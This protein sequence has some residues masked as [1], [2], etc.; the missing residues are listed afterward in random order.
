MNIRSAAAS[1][2]SHSTPVHIRHITLRIVAMAL[3]RGS[4]FQH[5]KTRRKNIYQHIEIEKYIYVWSQI[6]STPLRESTFSGFAHHL[7][8]STKRCLE[9]K[10]CE[11]TNKLKRETH[12]RAGICESH[13]TRKKTWKYTRRNVCCCVCVNGGFRFQLQGPAPGELSRGFQK[14]RQADHLSLLSMNR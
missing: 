12:G 9:T 14:W 1:P 13:N 4:T 10:I 8:N 11:R 3:L 7:Q 5:K 6:L 2:L